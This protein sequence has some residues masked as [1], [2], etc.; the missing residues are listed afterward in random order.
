VA[1]LESKIPIP[2]LRRLYLE[3]PEDPTLSD[4]DHKSLATLRRFPDGEFKN[5]ISPMSKLYDD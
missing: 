3:L 1:T 4:R 5:G 2:E